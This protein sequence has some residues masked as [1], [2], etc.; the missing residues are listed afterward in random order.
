MR[1]ERGQSAPEPETS[2]LSRRDLVRRALTVVLTVALAGCRDSRV[3][4]RT[5]RGASHSS[6]SRQTDV[7]Q[8]EAGRKETGRAVPSSRGSRA[9]DDRTQQRAP[10]SM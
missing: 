6:R 5:G 8:T 1:I 2:V 9:R 4:S 3:N 7:R 10:E